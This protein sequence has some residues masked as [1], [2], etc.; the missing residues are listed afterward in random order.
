MQLS[1]KVGTRLGQPTGQPITNEFLV[2][3]LR[4]N[5]K[6]TGRFMQILIQLSPEFFSPP[7]WSLKLVEISL[8][9]LNPFVAS[10]NEGPAEAA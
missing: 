2:T 9:T 10:I 1:N 6:S 7:D 8:K 5:A 3:H 4:F